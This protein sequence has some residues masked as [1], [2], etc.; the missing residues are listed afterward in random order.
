MIVYL[1]IF[2]RLL[3]VIKMSGTPLSSGAACWGAQVRGG[4]VCGYMGHKLDVRAP[5]PG[6]SCNSRFIVAI[7]FYIPCIPLVWNIDSF[8]FVTRFIFIAIPL[9]NG[10]PRKC[11][12]N[13]FHP[14][15]SFRKITARWLITRQSNPVL[16]HD[17]LVFCL[18]LLAVV[19]L[20]ERGLS[21]TSEDFL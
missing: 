20:L 10:I 18:I 8:N 3:G 7:F 15:G 11:N 19:Q 4:W 1:L 17:G 6:A 9:C 21:R 5:S 16:F 13:K 14:R 2:V 12:N